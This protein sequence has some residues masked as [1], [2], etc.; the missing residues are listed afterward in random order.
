MPLRILRALALFLACAMASIQVAAAAPPASGLLVDFTQ[1]SFFQGPYL[2]AAQD[3]GAPVA[4]GGGYAAPQFCE[5]ERDWTV[6]AGAIFL[7]RSRPDSMT[8]ITDAGAE[9]FNARQF[10][11][12]TSAG[13][14]I[15]VIRH[16][17]AFDLG[18]RFFQVNNMN[19]QRTIIP[20]LGAILNVNDPVLLGD[21]IL[22]QLY[23]T[24]VLSAEI[25]LRRNVTDNITVLAGFRYFQLDDNLRTRFDLPLD[26]FP[27]L[28][29]DVDGFNRL[30]G[31]QM[32]ADCTLVNIGPF[33]ITTEGK[34]GIYGNVARNEA[35]LS[36]PGSGVASWG[37]HGGDVSFVGDL[38][39]NGIYQVTEHWAVRGGY[40]LLWLSGIALSSDQFPF[41]S[42]HFTP[43]ADVVTNGDLFLHGA[44]VSIEGSW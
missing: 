3:D 1:T 43:D 25:N 33:R 10:T 15:N 19:A 14:D 39:F 13:P 27:P 2:T 31:G 24:S 4:S 6:W 5:V 16:G 30:Y 7:T 44:L 29:F 28:D 38:N 40:Q 9:L 23:G 35:R 36:T 20:S 17:D 21:D 41:V 26:I 22:S 8:L 11:F 34:A 18:F 37:T 32:G 42:H 12:G